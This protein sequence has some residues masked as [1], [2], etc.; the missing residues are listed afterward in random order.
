M[1]V[2]DQRLMV[3]LEVLPLSRFSRVHPEGTE[4]H[5]GRVSISNEQSNDITVEKSIDDIGLGVHKES[6]TKANASNKNQNRI[7]E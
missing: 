6:A 7:R 1:Q 3:R 2:V 4:S 5:V